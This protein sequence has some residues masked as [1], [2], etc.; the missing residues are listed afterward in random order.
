MKRLYYLTDSLESVSKISEDLHHDG[1]TDWNINVLSKDE[2]GLYHRHIHS[3]N[4]FQVNDIIHSG[5][6]GALLGGVLG[7]SV[8]VILGMWNPVGISLSFPFLI[9]VAGVFTLFGT[10]SG[11]LAGVT[12]ENYKTARFHQELENGHYLIMIDVSKDQEKIIRFHLGQYHP[13]ALLA[14]E[15]S[16]LI[17]PFSLNF[18]NCLKR[19]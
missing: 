4:L 16:S 3:A 8:A 10:W 7:L 13:E 14:A 1:I 15:G 12:R 19:S 9:L 17:T 5:E 18:W 11:G 2:A 6:L